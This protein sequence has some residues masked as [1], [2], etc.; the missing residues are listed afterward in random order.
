MIL[1][2]QQG[3][4]LIE[5]VLT[6]FMLSITLLAFYSVYRMQTRSLK[7]QDVRLQ[8]QQNARAAL[9]FMVR[10]MRN[11]GYNP[12]NAT[13]GGNCG[14]GAPGTPGI[15]S[16]APL[17]FQFS[18]DA[19]GDG[20]CLSSGENILYA[21]DAGTN[22]VTRAADGGAAED[23]TDGNTSA[24]QFL[25]Y[26]AQ[27]SSTAPPPYCYASG[28]DDPSGCSGDLAAN[29]ANIKRVGIQVTVE[30]KNANDEFGG[31]QLIAAMT[32]NVD[33]RNR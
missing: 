9:D 12:A 11:T 18:Y 15:I 3:F 17:S 14:N 29:V 24:L 2:I 31:G 32:S 27:T 8:A 28:V 33:L 6:T 5:V 10:E 13:S 4:T 30:S 1:K 19:D 25:F 16:V 26:P 20:D 22:N 7:S 21:Y 23:I